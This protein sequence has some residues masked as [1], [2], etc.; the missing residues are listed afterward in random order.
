MHSCGKTTIFMVPIYR[1]WVSGRRDRCGVKASMSSGCT[2][3]LA[4]RDSRLDGRVLTEREK[5]KSAL[6]S[7]L[8]LVLRPVFCRDSRQGWWGLAERGKSKDAPCFASCNASPASY[9]RSNGQ[10]DKQIY[11]RLPQSMAQRRRCG[12][13]SCRW[14]KRRVMGSYGR[15]S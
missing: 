11:R 4:S 2:L 14:G 1:W 5:I 9:G 12:M 3:C 6:C 10:T 15:E 7:V 13:V 8:C